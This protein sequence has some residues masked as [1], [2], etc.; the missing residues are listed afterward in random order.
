MGEIHPAPLIT[1]AGDDLGPPVLDRVDAFRIIPVRT[2]QP[3]P[4]VGAGK[5]A[6]LQGYAQIAVK[7]DGLGARPPAETNGQQ[8][9]IDHQRIDS[10]DDGVADGTD[11]VGDHQGLMAAQLKLFTIPGGYAAIDALG[12]RNRDQRPL[13]MIQELPGQGR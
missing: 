7:D 13:M 6:R 11:T 9:V 1:P 8:R 10:Y 2:G 4:A 12:V 3:T 5:K